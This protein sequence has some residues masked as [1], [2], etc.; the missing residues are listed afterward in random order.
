[1]KKNHSFSASLLILAIFF[2]SPDSSAQYTKWE[3]DTEFNGIKFKK[4]HFRDDGNESLFAS[5]ILKQET[6]IEGY[7]CHGEVDLS[8]NGKLQFFILSKTHNVAGNEFKKNTQVIIHKNKGY[9]I[10]CIYKPMV[11]GYHVK[12][13]PYRNPLFM[14]SSN[15]S[16]YPSGK[17]ERF[18]P[19]DNVEIQSIWCRPS[20]ARGAVTLYE[21]GK[22]KKCTSAKEQIIQGQK[23]EKNFSLKFDEDGTL[24]YWKKEKIFD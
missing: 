9:T 12:K 22:L 14:G 3:K 5:G 17:L 21:S 18:Q 24:T 19:V 4:I 23:V 8:K 16:L 2:I 11:Q 7:P 13:T 20:P 10:H 1:M 6:M 15:F